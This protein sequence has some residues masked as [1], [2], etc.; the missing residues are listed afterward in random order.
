MKRVYLILSLWM[1]AVCVCV[2]VDEA[3]QATWP[4]KKLYF[5]IR[6][7]DFRIAS[8]FLR[9]FIC[10]QYLCFWNL[11]SVLLFVLFR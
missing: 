2:C 1:Y 5:I 10:L 7:K 11:F 4:I 9:L 6:N 8:P 3:T